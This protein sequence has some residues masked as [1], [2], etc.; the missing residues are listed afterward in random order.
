MR[1]DGEEGG[2]GWLDYLIKYNEINMGRI[3]AFFHPHF[4]ISKI[5]PKIWRR[6]NSLLTKNFR[7]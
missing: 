3:F 4:K 6:L 5:P 1:C 2:G 7:F